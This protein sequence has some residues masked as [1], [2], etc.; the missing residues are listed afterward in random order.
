M[1]VLR[2]QGYQCITVNQLV[3]GITIINYIYYE[4]SPHN[5]RADNSSNRIST[6]SLNKQSILQIAMREINQLCYFSHFFSD[7]AISK[8][9]FIISTTSKRKMFHFD[10]VPEQIK[11]SVSQRLIS[12]V[13]LHAC[14]N[15]NSTTHH[16]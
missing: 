15:V 16:N 9:S 3:K 2:R 13:V 5:Q 12:A 8:K 14:Y 11:P 1:Y 6:H 4:L 10:D 7:H